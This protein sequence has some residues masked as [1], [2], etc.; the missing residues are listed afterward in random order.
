M[1]LS[2][3]VPCFNEEQGVQRLHEALAATLPEIVDRYEVILV[4]DGSTDGTTDGGTDGTTDGGTDGTTDGSTDGTWE[5][6]QA[7]P[8]ASF[9]YQCIR[10]SRN[11][12]KEAATTGARTSPRPGGDIT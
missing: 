7:L 1:D 8:K 5:A 4:D 6:L 2:I 12:G 10:L 9:A 3:V 11:F